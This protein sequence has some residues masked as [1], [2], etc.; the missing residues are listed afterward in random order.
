MKIFKKSR[1]PWLF[2]LLWMLVIFLFSAQ[3]GD[4]SGNTSAAFIEFLARV[5]SRNFDSLS[6]GEQASIIEGWQFIVRKAGH[7]SEYAL[8][9][10][11]FANALRSYD[12]KKLTAFLISV[13]AS[14]LYAVTDEIHQYFVPGRACAAL[15]VLIDTAGAIFGAALFFCALYIIRKR[16]KQKELRS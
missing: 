12:F 6:P 2:V 9:A 10:L 7:F 5:F 15:D 8:L 16:K 13:G 4:A 11:L 3:A 14:A 1:L